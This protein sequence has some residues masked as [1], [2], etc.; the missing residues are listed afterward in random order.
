MGCL[1]CEVELLKWPQVNVLVTSR[2]NIFQESR[3][4]YPL[5]KLRRHRHPRRGLGETLL[6][7]KTVQFTLVSHGVEIWPTGFCYVL[8]T[9]F[10]LIL[11]TGKRVTLEQ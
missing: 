10:L 5:E 4:I 2:Y 9:L 11:S 1:R 3:R 6:R 7:I 8:Q